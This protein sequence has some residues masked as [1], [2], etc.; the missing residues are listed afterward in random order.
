MEQTPQEVVDRLVNE[1]GLDAL[2]G[3][4][5]LIKSSEDAEVLSIVQEA[6]VRLGS[7]AK[8]RI[9]EFLEK[10]TLESAS[11][12]GLLILIETLGDI[13]ARGDIPVLY[14]YLKLFEQEIDQLYVYEAIA[15]L[16]GGKELLSLLELLLFEDEEKDL[17][18]DHIILILSYIRDRQALSFLVRLHALNDSNGEQEE[19][20]LL[21]VM[22]LLTQNP[23]WVGEL[24]A[25]SEGRKITEKLSAKIKGQIDESVTQRENPL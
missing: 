25:S 18:R 21:S 8:P 9:L 7:A 12:P 3:L 20:I 15:K 1:K 4:M 11:L 13:G 16:G 23:A 6:L 24:N 22:S 2:D 10:E 17:L 5:D 19:L 14:S